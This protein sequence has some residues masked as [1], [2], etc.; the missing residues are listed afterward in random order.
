MTLLYVIEFH[1]FK[2]ESELHNIIH[3]YVIKI[4]CKT[5]LFL[6]KMLVLTYHK[7]NTL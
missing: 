2:T 6:Y 5:V 4:E 1:Y 7:I 3:N